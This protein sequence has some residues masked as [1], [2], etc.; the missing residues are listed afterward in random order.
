MAKYGNKKVILGGHI[1]DSRKEADRWIVLREAERKGLIRNLELQRKFELVP[2]VTLSQMVQLK[3]KVKPV[4]RVIQK[5]ITYTCDFVYIKDGAQVVEDVK[6]SPKIIPHEFRLKEK[7][8]FWKY[9]FPIRKVFKASE[10]I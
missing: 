2:A 6:I 1:F 4:Q 5:A 7:L 3:T 8:F 9:G 10:P